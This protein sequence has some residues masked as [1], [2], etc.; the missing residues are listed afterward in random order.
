M[1]SPLPPSPSSSPFAP[2]RSSSFKESQQSR[3]TWTRRFF[4]TSQVRRLI[5]S[6]LPRRPVACIFLPCSAYCSLGLIR[7]TRARHTR[8]LSNPLAPQE[9]RGASRKPEQSC[10]VPN[11]NHVRGMAE[12]VR[13]WWVAM[14]SWLLD[15]CEE[16]GTAGVVTSMHSG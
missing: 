2:A 3:S 16:A 7:T 1:Q 13:G 5:L 6:T 8:A 9:A 4:K 15:M 10:H 12:S 14:R 11:C